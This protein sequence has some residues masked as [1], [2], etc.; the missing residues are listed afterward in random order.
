MA[1]AVSTTATGETLSFKNLS[2]FAFAHAGLTGKVQDMAKYAIGKI[3]GFPAECPDESKD[4]L[5]AGY[6]KRWGSLH[7]P[8]SF[9]NVGGSYLP[10]A[11]IDVSKMTGQIERRTISAEYLMNLTTHEYGVMGKDDPAW[12]EHVEKAREAMKDYANNRFNDLVRAAKAVI[13]ETTPGAKRTRNIVLFTASVQ[14]A[15]DGFDKSVKIKAK[16]G[17]GDNTANPVQFRMAVDA[18]WKAYNNK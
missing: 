17:S 7:P 4:E 14:K 12:R 11:S 10:E 13:A 16:A 18:F 2:D 5:K 1:K 8:V 6:H 3:A 15:F 9:I